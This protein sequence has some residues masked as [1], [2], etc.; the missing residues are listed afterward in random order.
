MVGK[1]E[2]LDRRMFVRRCVVCGYDGALLRGGAAERCARCGT[3]LRLRPARSYAEMEGFIGLP[4][5]IDAP[6][7]EPLRQQRLIHRW[8]AFCFFAMLFLIAVAYLAS[9]AVP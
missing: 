9:A 1:V 6:A 4:V 2:L 7:L 8:L 5:T 3:D